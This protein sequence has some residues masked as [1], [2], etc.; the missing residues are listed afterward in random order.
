CD[1]QAFILGATVER[2]EKSLA[3]YCQ[4]KHALGVSSGTDAI[5][6]ALMALEIGPGDE[7]ICPSFTFFATAGCIARVGATPVFADI[8]PATFNISPAE[9][10]R[11]LT[12]KTKA[13][14]PV[15]LYGQ[16]A[17]MNAINAI[18]AKHKLKVI[19]DAA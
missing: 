2:F 14:L 16:L 11:R 7:V 8:D 18:A 1:S 15:H 3:Q 9:I 4:T 10:E 5:V 6:A 13:I 12:P 19:E 17:D